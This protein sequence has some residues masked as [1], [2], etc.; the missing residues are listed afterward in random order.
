MQTAENS[1]H[2]Q[3]PWRHSTDGTLP[4]R[5]KAPNAVVWKDSQT[6]V[7]NVGDSQHAPVDFKESVAN[8]RL[9]AAAPQ[10]LAALREIIAINEESDGACRKRMGTRRGNSIVAARAAIALAEPSSN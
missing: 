6:I 3:G 10:L 9:I 5:I 4:I 8:A 1:K 2:T 7:A